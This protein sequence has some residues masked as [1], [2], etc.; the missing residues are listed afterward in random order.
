MPLDQVLDDLY[1]NPAAKKICELYECYQANTI[2]AKDKCLVGY[3]Q[4]NNNQYLEGIRPVITVLKS[5][6][7]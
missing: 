7:K 5:N 4:N 1:S 3:D 2:G 6:L